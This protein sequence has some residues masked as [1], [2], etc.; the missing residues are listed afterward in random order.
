M[1]ASPPMRILAV[2]LVFA[3]CAPRPAP[4][5][6]PS[7]APAFVD[8]AAIAPGIRLD[9]RYA[10][11]DNFLKKTVYPCAR[12]LLRKDAAE[13]VARAQAALEKEGYGLLLWDCYRPLAVQREMWKIVSDPKFVADPAKGSVH[14]RGGAIDVTLVTRD[15]QPLELP[16]AHDDFSEKAAAGAPASEAAA[17]HRALLRKALEAEGFT[18]LPSEWWHFSAKGSSEWPILD[19]PL[20]E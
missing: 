8:V 11:P 16:T 19:V 5:S 14:N 4:H 10:G 17:K 20:C 15:G 13:A 3:A 1:L 2:L 7:P 12:C 9:M 6:S 18:V